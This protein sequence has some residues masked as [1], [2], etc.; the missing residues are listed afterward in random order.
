MAVSLYAI[1]NILDKVST[2]DH[3]SGDHEAAP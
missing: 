3:L 1:K 2:G